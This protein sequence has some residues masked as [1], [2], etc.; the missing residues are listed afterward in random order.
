MINNNRQTLFFSA[1]WPVHVQKVAKGLL[2]S[3]SVQIRIGSSKNNICNDEDSNVDGELVVQ[4]TIDQE[5]LVVRSTHEKSIELRKRLLELKPNSGKTIIFFKT[6]VTCDEMFRF[7]GNLP[8]LPPS[9]ALHGN[10]QQSQRL[11]VMSEFRSSKIRLLFAT[12]VAARGLDIVDIDLVM[13]V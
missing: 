6:K 5:V 2:K 11:E 7:F 13:Q 9:A 1:T 10:L 12:D 8:N 4:E 3:N